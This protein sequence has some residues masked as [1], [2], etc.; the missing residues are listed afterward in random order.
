M[1]APVRPV[2]P[3]GSQP[4]PPK[5]DDHSMRNGIMALLGVALA[6]KVAKHNPGVLPVL[7]GV[8]RG[9]TEGRR[10]RMED[11][12]HA[13]ALAAEREQREY[14]RQAHEQG[15]IMNQLRLRSMGAVPD[16]ERETSPVDVPT[17]MTP[18]M[19]SAARINTVDPTRY[20]KLGGGYS[21]DRQNTPDAKAQRDRARRIIATKAAAKAA[22]RPINEDEASALADDE[23]AWRQFMADLRKPNSFETFK[24]RRDYMASHPIP[25]GTGGTS[26]TGSST[27]RRDP[28][29]VTLER[30]IGETQRQLAPVM[31][32]LE[33]LAKA[34]DAAPGV[35]QQRA[36]L[37]RQ[38]Q[39]MQSRLDSLTRVRDQR[40]GAQ[41]GTTPAVQ[42][43]SALGRGSAPGEFPA[44]GGNQQAA[45][46]AEF[47]K[48]AALYQQLVARP[49]VD[50]EEARRAYDESV[51][52]IARK[53]GQ[54]P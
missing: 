14:Q 3:A 13:E 31:R 44:P 52:M 50:P 1:T 15:N 16:G 30:Q 12:Q 32:Q 53:Y 29:L 18:G 5:K 38:R 11:E 7:S 4:E 33:A 8:S 20:Q 39:A 22:N 19:G 51:A 47:A 41:M 35:R 54:V 34:S 45:M 37:G 36:M 48:L 23:V 28:N 10:L 43:M 27:A 49:G 26:S 40:A 9:I 6:A 25:R 24:Q 42:D 2:P 21:L 46:D 17:F